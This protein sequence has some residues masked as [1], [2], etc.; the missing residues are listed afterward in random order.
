MDYEK[1][2]RSFIDFH[3]QH[4]PLSGIILPPKSPHWWSK[5]P[6]L[7]FFDPLGQNKNLELLC[8]FCNEGFLKCTG[9]MTCEKSTKYNMRDLI[10]TD[11]N[12]KLISAVYKCANPKED[13]KELPAH[14]PNILSHLPDEVDPGFILFKKRG[15][16]YSAYKQIMH[17]ISEGKKGCLTIR[18]KCLIYKFKEISC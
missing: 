5:L 18:K 1:Y 15:Y 9:K 3:R 11:R 17:Q 14:D 4:E 8:A 16:T 7:M 6:G 12:V 10:G 2:L 13:C